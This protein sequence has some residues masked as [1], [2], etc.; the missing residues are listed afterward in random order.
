MEA[1]G[2]IPMLVEVHEA[3]GLNPWGNGRSAQPNVALNVALKN[4]IGTDVAPKNLYHL[5][6]M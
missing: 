3:V 2:L 1:E 5:A 4:P 6:P